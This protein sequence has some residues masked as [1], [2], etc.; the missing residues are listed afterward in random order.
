[1]AARHR[2]M[3]QRATPTALLAAGLLLAL[4]GVA[5][6]Q[7]PA[8]PFC[9]S[10]FYFEVDGNAT[11]TLGG[12][13][14]FCFDFEGDEYTLVVKTEPEHGT[15]DVNVDDTF[16]YTPDDGYLSMD[17]FTF[18][19]VDDDG[20][21][22]VATVDILVLPP[23]HAPVCIT[24]VTLRVV[25]GQ[26]LPLDPTLVCTDPDGHLPFPELIT[27]P[28]H[29]QFDLTG[30]VIAYVPNPGYVGPD[31][32]QFR[33][34]DARGA[35]SNIATLHIIVEPPAPLPTGT[36]PPADTTAPSADVERAGRQKLKAL[37]SKGLRLRLT[38]DEPGTATISVLVSRATARRLRIPVRV[39]TTTRELDAGEHVLR[40]R[41]TARA[42]KRLRRTARIRLRVVA[43][44]VDAAGNRTE[45]AF[46]LTVRR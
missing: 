38:L 10:T 42:R 44:V 26:R 46:G 13:A 19:A 36:G 5:H 32:V 28:S 18:V 40:V 6:G 17:S 41:L 30:P 34:R 3:V 39:G 21:S 33:V 29:G 16:D 24:P 9:P 35:A 1:M 22:N 45:E 15:V 2:H 11:T 25:A 27:A 31:L 8:P 12:T 43:N 7:G 23:N 4:P 14:P 20:E 37:R